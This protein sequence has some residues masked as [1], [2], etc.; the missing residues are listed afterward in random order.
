MNGCWHSALTTVPDLQGWLP[1]YIATER[2]A[3][4]VAFVR[5]QQ[6]PYGLWEYAVRPQVSRWVTFDIL[7]TLSHLDEK[8]DWLS[9]EPRTPF[10]PYPR[11]QKR[12]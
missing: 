3:K 10:Q 4:M 6:G 9:Q 8:G 2:V 5:S 11:K 7:R 12:F 1:G